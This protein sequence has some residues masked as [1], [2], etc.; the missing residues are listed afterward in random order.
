[1]LDSDTS[2]EIE[3]CWERRV[4]TV[5]PAMLLQ[6]DRRE[7]G[8]RNER[9]TP[10]SVATSPLRSPGTPS[11]EPGLIRKEGAPAVPGAEGQGRRVFRRCQVR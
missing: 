10:A 11:S 7:Q 5:P 6:T 9:L 8:V 3:I 4:T 2:L 1:M